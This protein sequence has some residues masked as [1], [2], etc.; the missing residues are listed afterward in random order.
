MH[1]TEK[2]VLEGESWKKDA[3]NM[4]NT[5]FTDTNTLNTL[6]HFILARDLHVSPKIISEI[7]SIEMEEGFIY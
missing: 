1:I 5:L 2:A 3:N 4:L 6:S 7:D